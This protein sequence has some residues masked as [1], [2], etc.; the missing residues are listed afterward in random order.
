MTNYTGV[1]TLQFLGNEGIE[2]QRFQIDAPYIRWDAFCTFL[3]LHVINKTAL[4]DPIVT[5]ATTMVVSEDTDDTR[6]EPLLMSR[7]PKVVLY[8]DIGLYS[9]ACTV[10]S[11][12]RSYPYSVLLGSSIDPTICLFPEQVSVFYDAA[13]SSSSIFSK[14]LYLGAIA[15]SFGVVGV[16]GAVIVAGASALTGA[17]FYNEA[18]RKIN[19][20]GNNKNIRNIGHIYINLQ[21][22]KAIY[23]E[24]RYDGEGELNDDFN[25]YDF[26]K[27]IWDDISAASGNQHNFML[28]NDLERPSVL[29]IIDANFQKDDELTDDKIHTLKILSNDTVCRDFSYNSVIPS[30]LSATIGVAVQNPDS[31]QD[32]D[33]ASFA[34]LA[35]GIQSRFHVPVSQ[36]KLNP[37]LLERTEKIEK[38]DKLNDE[39]SEQLHELARFQSETADGLNQKLEEDGTVDPDVDEK[40][41]KARQNLSSVSKKLTK[42]ETLHQNDGVYNGTDGPSGQQYYAG[43]KKH[44]PNPSISAV[45]PLKFNAKLDGIG[46]ITIGNLF[47]VDPTR[48]PKGYKAA[49]I[50]FIVMGEQQQITAGQDWTTELNGQLVLLPQPQP[51]LAGSKKRSVWMEDTK[52]E[53]TPESRRAR[54]FEQ[55]KKDHYNKLNNIDAEQISDE[56]NVTGYTKPSTDGVIQYDKNPSN[57]KVEAVVK[58][59]NKNAGSRN[60][61][62]QPQLE[63]IIKQAAIET[64]LNVKIFS[65]GQVSKADFSKRGELGSKGRTGSA[66][67]DKGYGADVWLYRSNPKGAFKGPQLNVTKPNDTALLEAFATACKQG[68]ATGIGMGRGYMGNVGMHVDIAYGNSS[69]AGGPVWGESKWK[70]VGDPAQKVLKSYTPPPPPS[71]LST[72]MRSNIGQPNPY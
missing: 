32:L 66:R 27:K 22:M 2:S 41:S 64:K 51:T 47:K 55:E 60:L 26:I 13:G 59:V 23:K 15:L 11:S 1:N 31:V 37:T 54:N 58:Y 71:W 3:N 12:G 50:G 42:I 28:H 63:E 40:I 53:S 7:I 44:I 67:H 17:E 48:L 6:I 8:D 19:M 49:D 45:I 68:G 5:F 72:L 34:A 57:Q 38:L 20:T 52:Y 43:Y 35:K 62:C 25:L 36:T 18:A 4:G 56:S 14:A 61:L 10:N 24:Q 33:G 30:A 69:D 46:G 29:R 65:G 39:V 21:K 70:Y 9:Y 16:V